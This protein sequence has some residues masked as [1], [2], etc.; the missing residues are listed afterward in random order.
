VTAWLSISAAQAFS[1]A[2]SDG[3]CDG[4]KADGAIC[5]EFGEEKRRCGWRNGS[6]AGLA[7]IVTDFNR[8]CYAEF[9]DPETKR[10]GQFVLLSANLD[11]VSRPT[12]P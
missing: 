9:E 11:T 7:A 4:W 2:S 8:Q 1:L 12:L 10:A 6:R 3:A 5:A